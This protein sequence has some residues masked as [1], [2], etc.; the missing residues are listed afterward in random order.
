MSA[1]RTD[2][3]V[4]NTIILFNLVLG[5]IQAMQPSP[6]NGSLTMI[7]YVHGLL[8]VKKGRFGVCEQ[9]STELI[10]KQGLSVGF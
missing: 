8:R 1:H 2:L 7:L 4:L 6:Q 5:R 9:F 10:G 3:P